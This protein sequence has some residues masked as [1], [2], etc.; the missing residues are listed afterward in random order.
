MRIIG[1]TFRGRRIQEVPSKETRSTT[2]RV[3]EAWASSI[4]SLSPEGSLEGMCVLDAFAGSGALGLE[5]LSRGAGQCVFIEKNRTALTVL[6]ANIAGLELSGQ[7]APVCAAD[8]LSLQILKC[9]SQSVSFDLVVLDPPYEIPRERTGQL[10][11]TLAKAGVLARNCLV[12]YE[13]SAREVEDLD[14]LLLCNA[15]APRYLELVKRKKYG[16][17]CIDY[18]WCR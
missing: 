17:I 11:A 10:L 16:T 7:R 8:S 15:D 9:V 2:D 3:R 5:L 12:S 1:G 18:Y 13:H 6:R 14:N 4:I